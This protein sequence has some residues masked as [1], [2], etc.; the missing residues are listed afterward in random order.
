MEV[1]VSES[2]AELTIKVY[3][4]KEPVGVAILAS[5]TVSLCHALG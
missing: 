2:F 4:L 1:V 5:V 3:T